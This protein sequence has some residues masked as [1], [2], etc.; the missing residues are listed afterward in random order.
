VCSDADD[1]TLVG[2][3][4]GGVWSG[5]GVTGNTFD[6]S[7]GTQTLTYTVSGDCGGSDQ[8]IITVNSAPNVDA[9][10]YGPVCKD[11]QKITL[12]GSPAGGV[13]TGTGVSLA[14]GVYTF[15]PSYGTQTLTYTYTGGCSGS[16]N[17][18]I[19]VNNKPYV[20]PGKYGPLC[21]NGTKITLGGTP[22][23]GTWSGAGVSYYNGVYKFDPRSGTQTI[24][25]TYTDRNGCTN[26]AWVCI[27]VIHCFEGCSPGYYKTH[28]QAWCNGTPSTFFFTKFS[29]ITNKRGL[30]STTTMAQA[31]GFGGGGY[32]ALARHAV[33]ALQNACHNAVDYP[34]TTTQILTAVKNMFNS[35]FTTLGGKNYSGVE[36]LKNELDRANNL[37]CPLNNSN[38]VPTYKTNSVL[39]ESTAALVTK[40]NVDVYP[41]PY[42]D[43]IRFVIQSP[44]SG[45]ANLQVSNVLGQKIATVYKGRINA[46]SSQVIE[47][48][49]PT[50]IPQ[51][52]IYTLTIGSERVVGKLLR[53]D[54]Q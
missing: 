42:T 44:V 45:E 47:F 30:P 11:A 14:N 25:Y 31:I 32:Y 3:P 54:K 28:Y 29:G 18:T 23:G 40:L 24:K 38:A 27:T 36:A 53:V 2:T 48:R 13:W 41:N 34:Y 26:S 19:V 43:V 12:I 35:G 4:A 7:V 51:A 17:T 1:I 22:A 39:D 16:D 9:G 5:T 50:P 10:D 8:T 52:V 15:N 33:A 6:P 49:I 21:D 37:N 46:Q 20:N